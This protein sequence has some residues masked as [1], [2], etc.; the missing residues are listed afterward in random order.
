MN[1]KL[2]KNNLDN[3]CTNQH[4]TNQ[5]TKGVRGTALQKNQNSAE[6]TELYEDKNAEILEKD[7]FDAKN[8]QKAQVEKRK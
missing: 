3:H 7:A 5:T 6:Q 2:Q 1:A 8:K 4:S